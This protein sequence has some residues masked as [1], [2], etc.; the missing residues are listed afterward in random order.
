[1]SYNESTL[2]DDL[3]DKLELLEPGLIY[4]QKEQYIPNKFGTRSFIDF[5]ARDATNK[6]VLVEV[7]K[8]K[9]AEREAVHEVLKYIDG[10]K[11]H[12]GLKEDEIRVFVVSPD[13]SELFVP[14][15]SLVHRTHCSVVGF[16][17]RVTETGEV[18]GAH[19]LEPL[20]GT[21]ERFVAPWHELRYFA[22]ETACN[23][24]IA[25]YEEACRQKGIESFVLLELHPS[26]S[27]EEGIS[28]PKQQSM[29]K[30]IA[31]M[32][33]STPEGYML[34]KYKRALYFAMQ[35]LSESEYASILR[36][37]GADCSETFEVLE[38]M[39]DEEE[40]LCTL[41]EA[42]LDLQPRPE[43]DFLEIGYPAKIKSRL[44]EDDGWLIDTVHRFGAFSRNLEILSDEVIVDEICGQDGAG[45]QQFSKTFDPANKTEVASI[46]G[47]IERCLSQNNAWRKQIREA[48]REIVDAADADAVNFTL[49]NPSTALLTFYLAVSHGE[50]EQYVPSYSFYREV[51]GKKIIIFGCLRWDGS[52]AKLDTVLRK[53]YGS[54]ISQMLF[55][56]TWGGYDA[57]DS[58]VMRTIGFRYRS[59]KVEIAGAKRS[60]FQM[61]EEGWESCAEFHPLSDFKRIFD[62]N[63]PLMREICELYSENWSGGLV[64]LSGMS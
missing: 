57:Q 31:E 8:T 45:Y 21:G 15:S 12:L 50:P 41:H 22:D 19:E 25:A 10:V 40:R 60:F 5:V 48:L 39:E 58:K 20:G 23:E 32:S 51:D 47:G 59:F 6:L 64:D 13:W 37:S 16:K 4:S 7:K 33:G 53:H 3:I 55:S 62:E 29:H 52:L 63:E 9:A 34:P 11:R 14:F 46:V 42:V 43:C 61:T 26:K 44:L 1:M 18:T 49:F 56:L 54:S 28:S 35:Q 27:F 17:L 30:I 2:R 38:D 36:A 24:A